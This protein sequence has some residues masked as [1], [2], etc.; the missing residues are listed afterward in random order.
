MEIPFISVEFKLN[1][2]DHRIKMT[3]LD[4][5]LESIYHFSQSPSI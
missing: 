5:I 3:H 2:P 1:G 4:I